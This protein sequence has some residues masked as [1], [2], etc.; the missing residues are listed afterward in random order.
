[1]ENKRGATIKLSKGRGEN[2]VII[3]GE[4]MP[5]RYLS[6]VTVKAPSTGFKEVTLTYV[7]MGDVETELG[8]NHT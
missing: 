7:V 4:E 2:I 8:G 6:D 5:L 3:N 1:M